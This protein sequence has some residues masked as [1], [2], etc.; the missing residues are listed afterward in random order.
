MAGINFLLSKCRVC[1]TQV[2]GKYYRLMLYST[3]IVLV[4]YG[5]LAAVLV[6]LVSENSYQGSTYVMAAVLTFLTFLIPGIIL[7]IF[8]K[9]PK[10]ICQECKKQEDFANWKREME[11]AK[12]AKL[13]AGATEREIAQARLAD[14]PMARDIVLRFSEKTKTYPPLFFVDSVIAATNAERSGDFDSA[15]A[16]YEALGL[17]DDAGR[18]RGMSNVKKTVTVDLNELINQL[19]YGGL[20]LNY[21]CPSCRA[22]LTIDAKTDAAGLKYCGYCGT[23]IDLETLNSLLRTALR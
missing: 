12:D 23:A 20:A 16:S 17:Y 2:K 3:P 14:N 10:Y 1:G 19:R 7:L 5:L 21:R 15:I 22:S 18:V 4:F 8:L 9:K 11:K 6:E 13:G